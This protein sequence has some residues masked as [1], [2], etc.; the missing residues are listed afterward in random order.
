M[1]QNSEYFF[2]CDSLIKQLYT[3]VVI[4]AGSRQRSSFLGS[5]IPRVVVQLIVVPRVVVLSP[6]STAPFTLF[7]KTCNLF[8]IKKLILEEYTKCMVYSRW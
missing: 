5:V 3:W 7:C 2:F 8:I 6:V 4:L 1:V